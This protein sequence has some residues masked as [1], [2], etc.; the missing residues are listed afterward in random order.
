MSRARRSMMG[1]SIC[2]RPVLPILR[3]RRSDLFEAGA[4]HIIQRCCLLAFGERTPED[5]RSARPGHAARVVDSR[6]AAAALVPSRRADRKSH[7]ADTDSR[8]CGSHQP[9][10]CAAGRLSC[11]PQP[12]GTEALKAATFEAESLSGWRQAAGPAVERAI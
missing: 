9:I 7:G 5:D 12:S 2:P 8:A 6:E 3:S 4:A 10:R 1:L 11:R